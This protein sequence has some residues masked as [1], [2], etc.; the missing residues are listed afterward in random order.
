[1]SVF[2]ISSTTGAL[3]A[4]GIP[5]A[6][7]VNPV[8]VTVESMGRF[9]YVVNQGS[10]TVST[11]SINGTTGGL[12]A[13]GSPLATGGLPVSVTV[14]LTGRWVYVANFGSNDVSA[15][16]I[17]QTTGALSAA[18]TFVGAPP[19]SGSFSIAGTGVSQ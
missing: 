6:T 7:G 16:T 4:V 5:V 13:V 12:T 18:G 1:M 2:A 10:N 11:F 19:V 9:A 14:D 8:S 17:D 3:A 15:Y